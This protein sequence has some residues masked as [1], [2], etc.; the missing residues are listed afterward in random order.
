MDPVTALV[1]SLASSALFGL[2]GF[3][4]GI[5]MANRSNRDARKLAL[6]FDT[7]QR[8]V[9]VLEDLRAILKPT[10]DTLEFVLGELAQLGTGDEIHLRR[11]EAVLPELWQSLKDIRFWRQKSMTWLMLHEIETVLHFDALQTALMHVCDDLENNRFEER[12]AN[13]ARNAREAINSLLEI[14]LRHLLDP[15]STTEMLA[16]SKQHLRATA[17]L[18]A[19]EVEAEMERRRALTASKNK[20]L[21]E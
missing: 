8:Y 21:G 14:V 15:A 6:E 11:I 9:T 12:V 17:A 1:I 2:A 5:Y 10:T 3:G 13:E 20:L 18:K 16:N 4:G 7:R 19:T